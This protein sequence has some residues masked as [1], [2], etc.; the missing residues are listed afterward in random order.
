MLRSYDL[1]GCAPQIHA[2]AVVSHLRYIKLVRGN[3]LHFVLPVSVGEVMITEDVG[4]GE[5]LQ[6]FA[7]YAELCAREAG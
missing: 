4:N 1:I 3:R 5:L 2:E 6:A 7:Q